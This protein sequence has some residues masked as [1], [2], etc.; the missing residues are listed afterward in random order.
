MPSKGHISCE[1]V[2]GGRGL[3]PP[4]GTI[5]V[6]ALTLVYFVTWATLYGILL[7]WR[8]SMNA[9]VLAFVSAGTGFVVVAAVLGVAS[10]F[11]SSNISSNLEQAGLH[12]SSGLVL[13]GLVMESSMIFFF[14][15]VVPAALQLGFLAFNE[16]CCTW[17]GTE[18]TPFVATY[19]LSLFYYHFGILQAVRLLNADLKPVWQVT[20]A[21]SPN[22]NSD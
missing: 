10:N 9:W 20:G 17:S 21:V 5:L 8:T 15:I 4:S 7:H 11:A 19:L 22:K 2:T 14:A 16:T 6:H 13:V 3:Q 12:Y 18:S 1:I